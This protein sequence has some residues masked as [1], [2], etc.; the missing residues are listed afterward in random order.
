MSQILLEEENAYGSASAC[1]EDDGR[2]VYLY[3]TAAEGSV[4]E[5]A[6][7][8]LRNRIEAPDLADDSPSRGVAPL[9]RRANCAHSEGMPAFAPESLELVWFPDGTGVTLYADG[10]LQA[11]LPPWAG[12][13]AV[14]GYARDA[15]GFEAFT[16]PLPPAE[17]G[18]YARLEENRRFW[19]LRRRPD[20]WSGYRDQLLAWYESFLDPH[21]Q[22]FAVDARMPLIGIA[23][24][25]SED[26]VVFT[27][28][29]MGRQPQP[30]IEL[31]TDHPRAVMRTEI[32]CKFPK[33]S[34]SDSTGAA[35]AMGR[36]AAYPWRTG[37]FFD[38]GHVYE[39]SGAEDVAA[40]LLTAD[41][42]AAGWNAALPPTIIL[43]EEYPLRLLFA[44]PGTAQDAAVARAKGVDFQLSR[45]A[46]KRSLR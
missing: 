27:T 42:A 34:D 15:V 18:L 30:G 13:D 45:M 25:D 26:A 8:W 21:S 40:F 24:F 38:D 39:T 5:P 32:V 12:R 10:Q 11:V 36:M 16:L 29:G 46:E 9:M 33:S 17:S 43:D 35:T 6:A 1:I 22:Y 19:E 41:P 44:V 2:T 23:R 14:Q 28:V 7:V 3:R 37:R 31:H 20:D 4:V